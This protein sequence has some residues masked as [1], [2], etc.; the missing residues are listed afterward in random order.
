MLGV[1]LLSFTTFFVVAGMTGFA[2]DGFGAEIIAHRGASH[3]APE[4]TMASVNLAWSRNTDAV[5]IDIYLSRDGSIVV[6]HDETTKRYGGPDKK[7]VSQT[8]SELKKLDVGRWKDE[9]WVGER[10]PT[11]AEVL[12][13]IPEGKR[14]FIEVKCGPEIVPELKRVLDK[15]AKKPAQTAVISFSLSAVRE[16]KKALP[17]LEVSWL[18]AFKKDETTG[19]YTP[20]AESLIKTA[21]GAGL[22]GVDLRDSPVITPELVKQVKDAGLSFYVWTINSAQAARRLEKCGVD[23]IT[24]DRPQWLRKQLAGNSP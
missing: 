2:S 14:L 6:I 23:G 9:K 22:D 7:V 18:S 17:K 10:I 15:A 21:T 3:D 11:L 4:N 24:T 19:K 5:E 12:E 20:S 13:T 16:V 1:R 8:L